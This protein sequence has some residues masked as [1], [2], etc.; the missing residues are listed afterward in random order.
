MKVKNCLEHLYDYTAGILKAIALILLIS[1]II[2]VICIRSAE[3]DNEI[4]LFEQTLNQRT[5]IENLPGRM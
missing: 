2:A 1:V 5:A 3:T 4:K